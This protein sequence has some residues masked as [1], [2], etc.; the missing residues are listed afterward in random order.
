MTKRLLIGLAVLAAVAFAASIV[1]FS[2]SGGGQPLSGQTRADFMR[3]AIE[4]CTALQKAS[5]GNQGV[6]QARIDRFCG[7]YAD[8]LVKRVSTADL[9]RLTDKAPADIQAEMRPRM[10]DADRVCLA[11]VDKS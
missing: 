3:S 5:P 9:D 8:A 1:G 11:E 7:C 4:A 6:E 10:E 2:L